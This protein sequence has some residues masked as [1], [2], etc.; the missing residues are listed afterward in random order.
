M[1]SWLL[2]YRGYLILSLVE[3]VVLGALFLW[4]LPRPT[5]IAILDP[6]PRPSPTT[7]AIAIYVSGAVRRP[8]VYTL[9]AGSRLKDALQVAGGARDDAV[10]DGLNL[11]TALHDG[12]RVHVPAPGEAPLAVNPGSPPPAADGP[13]NINAASPAELDLL[14]G[15]GPA[16]AQ[17]IIEDRQANG[18]Y[19]AV[20]QLARVRGIGPALVEKLRPLVS[21]H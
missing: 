21:L 6:T 15:I 10:L 13:V 14:P 9:P 8:E 11:A 16:L 20:D 4:R 12:Q 19:E 3:A 17:R 7:A 1:D 2:R 5:P 18:P